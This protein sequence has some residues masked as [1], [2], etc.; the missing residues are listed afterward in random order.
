[1]S[2]SRCS[3]RGSSKCPRR[4]RRSIPNRWSYAAQWASLEVVTA[5]ARVDNRGNLRGSTTDGGVRVQGADDFYKLSKAL[6]AAG[7]AELRKELNKSMR[8]AAK[9]LL[10]K[11][12]A[13]AAASLPRKNGLNQ[14]IAKK[15]FR[16]QTRTGAS[17]AGVRIVGT[18]VDPRIDEGR[19]YHP[20]F[21]RTPGVVQRV[22]PGYFSETLS[23]EG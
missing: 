12:R 8:D 17:T 21:G 9:P 13:A 4:C 7:Q 15:P 2:K 20:V 1:M 22:T 18:N 19:L 14:R 5:M 6:K 11:V 16:V 10:P 23:K 3:T